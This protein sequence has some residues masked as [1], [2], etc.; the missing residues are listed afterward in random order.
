M[1]DVKPE[2]EVQG[3]KMVLWIAILISASLLA[4]GFVWAQKK[5]H[6]VADG[7]NTTISTIYQNPET[8]LANAGVGLSQGDEFRLSTVE[9]M[10]ETTIIVY[11]AVPVTV[12]YQGKTTSLNTGKPNVAETVAAMGIDRNRVRIEP[13]PGTQPTEGMN[14]QV[15]DLKEE[16]IEQEATVPFPIVR[17]PDPTMERGLE[18]V[19]SEGRDGQK[20]VKLRLHYEDGRQVAS[21][22]L[23]ETVI[24]PAEPEVVRAGTR[25]T[26]ETS[27]GTMRFRTVMEMEA[28]AYTPDDGGG[29]GITA[30]GVPAHRGVVAVDPQVIPLGTRLYVSGYGLALAADTGG[31]IRGERID[32]CVESYGEAAHYGRRDVRVYVLE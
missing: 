17:Q 26:V 9:V 13:I 8:I 24:T 23:E 12:T 16:I 5:V 10:N 27:R 11:R 6:I 15:Y 31:A 14:I 3:R 29:H 21:E 30:S 32:L 4:T 2:N 22:V 28:T 20:K 25:D 19:V 7:K 1:S 18:T